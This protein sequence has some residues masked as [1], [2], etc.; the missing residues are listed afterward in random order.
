MTAVGARVLAV[1]KVGA[2]RRVIVRIGFPSYRESHTLKFGEQ[3]PLTGFT[4]NGHLDLVYHEDPH[5]K[6]GQPFP[7]WTLSVT[8]PVT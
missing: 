1:D 3:E 4:P 2:R 8:E 7:L 6:A 5:P